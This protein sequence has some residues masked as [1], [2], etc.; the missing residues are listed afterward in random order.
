MSRTTFV[1]CT[2]AVLGTGAAAA[3]D[4]EGNA[5]P[6][7]GDTD[8]VIELG[9]G[10]GVVPQYEG[11]K[12]YRFSPFPIVNLDYLSVPGLFSFGSI[13]PQRGGFSIGPSFGYVGKRDS[14]DY[15]ELEG[16]RDVDTTYQAGVR[17]GY[18]WNYAEIYGAARYAFGG[19]EGIVGD[20]GASLVARPLQTL[21]VKAGPVATFASGEYM[22]D[23][24]GVSPAESI[25]SGGRFDDYDPKS[26][27][28]TVGA[29]ASARYEFRPAWFVNA[30]ASW[31]RFVGD[32]KDSPIVKA[33]DENQYTFGLGISKRFQLDLF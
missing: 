17:L 21:Q 1:L 32:A 23:Y 9:A 25:G 7:A 11:S 26:G 5:A 13:D 31:N 10:G 28:K 33:G 6:K 14:G 18:E 3:A 2:L 24:F 29:A 22:N 15:D 4:L 19:A 30:D 16:L 8:V 20:L 12:D 27:F